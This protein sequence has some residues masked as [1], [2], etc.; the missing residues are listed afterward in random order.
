LSDN[1]NLRR[2]RPLFVFDGHCVLC[3][4]GA[5][6]IMRHDPD[7]RIQ[8]ASAQSELGQRLYAACGMSIDDSY[9]LIDREGWHIKS[10]GY[11]QVAQHL[12]GWWR[13]ARVVR[14]IPRTLRDWAYDQVALNRYRWFGRTG[15]C[16]LLTPEQRNQLVAEDAQLGQQLDRLRN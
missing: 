5:S 12:G 7:G 10:G 8:F 4:G 1:P 13:L 14:L 9:L 16:K 2:D 11:L 3:S 6:F 15:Y